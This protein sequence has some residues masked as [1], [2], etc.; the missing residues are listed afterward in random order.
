MH[1][2]IKHLVY[3]LDRWSALRHKPTYFFQQKKCQHDINILK[4][5]KKI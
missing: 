1:Y 5:G 2:N 3:L 4:K